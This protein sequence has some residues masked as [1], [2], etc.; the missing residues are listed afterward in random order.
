MLQLHHYFPFL[1]SLNYLIIRRK[2]YL[3]WYDMRS[4]TWIHKLSKHITNKVN[5]IF[6]TSNKMFIITNNNNMIFIITFFIL[7]SHSSLVFVTIINNMPII[8]EIVTFNT[9]E[10]RIQISSTCTSI[11]LTYGL[12]SPPSSVTKSSGVKL[13]K[14]RPEIFFSYLHLKHHSYHIPHLQHH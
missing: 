14:M 9:L 5:C 3:Y 2:W 7:L 1:S 10:S 13:K 4:S 11:I 8:V 12:I 6:T